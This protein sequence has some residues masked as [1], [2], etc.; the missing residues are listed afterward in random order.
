MLSSEAY[1]D[2][3]EDDPSMMWPSPVGTRGLNIG[4]VEVSPDVDLYGEL[5]V[6]GYLGQQ[7]LCR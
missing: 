5:W 1:K 6:G 7:V 3:V 4:R 2:E